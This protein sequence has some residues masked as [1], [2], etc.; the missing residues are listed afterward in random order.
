MHAQR[1]FEIVT[2]KNPTVLGLP[3]DEEGYKKWKALKPHNIHYL[4]IRGWLLGCVH[5]TNYVCHCRKCL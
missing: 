1:H 5:D 3:R 4:N 2:F